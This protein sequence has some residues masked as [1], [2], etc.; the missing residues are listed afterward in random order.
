MSQRTITVCD[1]CKEEVGEK[2]DYVDAG[3]YGYQFHLGCLTPQNVQMLK[4]LALDEIK[5]QYGTG[6][7]EKLIYTQWATQMVRDA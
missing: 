1:K 7:T 5:Y 2:E 3:V 6:D 4:M